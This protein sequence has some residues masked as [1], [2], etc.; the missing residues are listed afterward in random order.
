MEKEQTNEEC[1]EQ[2]KRVCNHNDDTAKTE[3]MG[4][5][6]KNASSRTNNTHSRKRQM[7][8]HKWKQSNNKTQKMNKDEKTCSTQRQNIT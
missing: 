7:K 5:I 6:S 4:S 3:M 8:E 2:T 1:P